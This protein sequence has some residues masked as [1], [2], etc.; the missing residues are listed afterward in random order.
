MAEQRRGDAVLGEYRLAAVAQLASER[1]GAAAEVARA[2]REARAAAERARQGETIHA[3]RGA[4]SQATQTV[5]EQA[6]LAAEELSRRGL[7]VHP[8]TP[9][10]EPLVTVENLDSPGRGPACRHDRR[11]RTR[12]HPRAGRR[13][14][15]FPPRRPNTSTH[16]SA[17]PQPV[18]RLAGRAPP[19]G[20][21]PGAGR[22]F[23]LVRGEL[24]GPAPS[25]PSS[26]SRHGSW[27]RTGSAGKPSPRSGTALKPTSGRPSTRRPSGNA[28]TAAR[29]K[30][31][32]PVMTSTRTMA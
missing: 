28:S 20:G 4:W 11:W 17:T 5:Q 6:R 8:S 3:E 31:P 21:R 15:P 7:P 12:D 13:A 27:N 2:H 10:A 16:L 18:V 32:T 9:V 26:A 1:A 25:V 30:Q 22:G 19:D 23:G 24:P 29:T 14:L